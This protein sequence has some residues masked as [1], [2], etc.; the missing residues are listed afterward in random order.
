MK[1][2]FFPRHIRIVLVYVLI[3]A[4]WFLI[5]DFFILRFT[6]DPEW[7]IT[8]E[9]YKELLFIG[10][11][12]MLLYFERKRADERQRQADALEKLRIEKMAQADKMITL[13][14]LVSGVA[15]EINNPTNFIT[16]NTPVLKEAW[17]G[18]RPVLDEYYQ[19]HGDFEVGRFYYSELREWMEQLFDGVTEGAERITRI[20]SSLKDFARPDPSDMNQEV[21]VNL[22]IQEAISLLRN[23]IE[24]RTTRFEVQCEQSLPPITGSLQKLEQVLINL[25]QN[26]LDSLNEM[27]QGVRVTSSYDPAGNA[28]LVEV[29]D[30]GS[31]I[32]PDIIS[33]IC[34]PFFT[35]KRQS[36]GTGLGLSIASRMIEEH[37]GRLSFASE[38]GRGTTATLT[39]PVRK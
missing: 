30:E 10:I 33:R 7:I 26:S 32:E 24:K 21:N 18:T 4:L 20:I 6:R 9:E 28:V 11:T 12:A 2:L 14:T 13:G 8:I 19:A 37:G 15:H 16:L 22:V 31:G 39:L 27:Q 17:Q 29:K 5:T 23:P 36:G 25:I 38:P 34:D 35:T 3:G 1:N